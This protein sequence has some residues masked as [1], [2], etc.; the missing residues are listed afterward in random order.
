MALYRGN[1]NTTY[2]GEFQIS[3]FTNILNLAMQTVYWKIGLV[4]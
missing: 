1:K 2:V 4:L 3:S